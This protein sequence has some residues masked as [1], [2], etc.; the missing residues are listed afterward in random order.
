M[1][2]IWLMR[3]SQV[4]FC[5]CISFLSLAS[6]PETIWGEPSE[7]RKDSF[8]FTVLE[9]LI[10]S[11][12]A[13]VLWLR[14]N[15]RRNVMYLGTHRRKRKVRMLRSKTGVRYALQRY[16]FNHLLASIRLHF[17]IVHSFN[18]LC[19]LVICIIYTNIYQSV[20]C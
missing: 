12:P 18:L 4:Y 5:H 19:N 10:Q 9:V 13:L 2:H 8:W 16:M 17:L 6:L 11:Q 14:W 7:R 1:S 15:V 3:S 20:R